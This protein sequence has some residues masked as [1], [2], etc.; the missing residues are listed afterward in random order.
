MKT[1]SGE[2]KGNFDMGTFFGDVTCIHGHK[3]R[4]FNIGR[5][6]YVACDKCRRYVSVGANLMSGWRQENKDIWQANF[7]RL[8]EYQEVEWD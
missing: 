5:G 1:P 2:V 7:D 4:L 6:H 8:R 3:T